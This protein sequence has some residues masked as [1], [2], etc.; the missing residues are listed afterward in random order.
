M[1]RAPQPPLDRDASTGGSPRPRARLLIFVITAVIGLAA[2]S[3]A[4]RFVWRGSEM[5]RSPPASL[6][7]AAPVSAALM[8][9]PFNLIDPAGH[10]VSD[11][12]FRGRFM[13]I[14]FGYT[15]CPDHCPTMLMMT[16]A[17]LEALGPRA[18]QVQPIFVTV[19]PEHDTPGIMGRYASRFSS[20]ILGL[21]GSPAQIESVEKVFGVQTLFRRTGPEPSAYV[22]DHPSTFY[23]VGPD[24][25]FIAEL[26]TDGGANDLAARIRS[27]L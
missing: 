13:L 1:N 16:A 24:G 4:A 17:A 8:G 2:V 26:G 10:P 15:T 7:P 14:Y 12:D 3:G 25:R 20:R 11:R 19:D 27:R 9:G 6:A 5:P 18:S 23:L 22:I 21:T